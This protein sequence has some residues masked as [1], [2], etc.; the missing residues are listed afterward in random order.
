V[1]NGV[2]A[3]GDQLA[4]RRTKR[5]VYVIPPYRLMFVSVA[6][7][8]CTSMKWVMAELADE[9]LSAFTLGLLPFI[10]PDHAVHVRSRFKKTL[11]VDQLDPDTRAE[12]HPD[13]GWFIFS[14][15]RDPRSRLFSAW[16]DKLL[17]Q[18]AV[19]LQ[20][21]AHPWYPQFSTDPAIITAEFA[22]FVDAMSSQPQLPLH[23]D[24]H[25]N[26]QT[27]LLHLDAVPY[28][29]IYPIEQLSQLRADL[30]EHLQRQGWEGTLTFRRTNDTPLRA[31]ASAFAG[32]VRSK[33][34]KLYAADF[35]NFGHLWNYAK[36]EQTA[37]WSTAA[38][39]ELELRLAFGRRLGEVRQIAMTYRRR[40]RRMNKRVAKL[41]RDVKQ[42]RRRAKSGSAKS[43]VAKPRGSVLRRLARR[44]RGRLLPP[45]K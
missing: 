6:K 23:R 12:I 41:E 21:N 36:I 2:T 15:V 20:H 38:L 9:D 37:E 26:S 44:V 13:N 28:S 33:I 43:A 39:Q 40:N 42:L 10:S 7:N 35:E 18:D 11:R 5:H 45:K 25:F 8:A 22:R 27:N 30:T 32:D 3:I 1:P 31:N 4:S 34:E 19:Y 24:R 16:Q 14:I 17:L 29:K